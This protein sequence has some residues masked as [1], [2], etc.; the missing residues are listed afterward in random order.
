M[1]RVRQVR[2]AVPR[3]LVRSVSEVPVAEALAL[4]VLVE[5]PVAEALAPEV[6]AAEEVVL[7]PS[8]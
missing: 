5:V 7:A 6:I 2:L 8:A 4:P 3:R 1:R